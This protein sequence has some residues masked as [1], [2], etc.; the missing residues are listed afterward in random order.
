MYIYIIY[1]CSSY[2]LASG[3]EVA[4]CLYGAIPIAT[5]NDLQVC[6]QP[7]TRLPT[8]AISMAGFRGQVRTSPEIVLH[9]P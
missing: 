9:L 5:V 1:V 4:E 7:C 2:F 6:K 8:V 3:L